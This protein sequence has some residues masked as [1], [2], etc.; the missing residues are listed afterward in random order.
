MKILFVGV[1]TEGSTN[2]SQRDS[3]RRI[4]HDVVEF[5][6]RD[7]SNPTMELSKINDKS[8]DMLLIAK[9]NNIHHDVIRY[10][11]KRNNCKF[12]YWF[13][14]PLMSFSQEMLD[15]ILVSDISYFDKK[16]VLDI[17]KKYHKDC[18]YLCEGYDETIDKVKDVNKE[19][20]VSFIGT[21]YGERENILNNIDN[22]KLIKDAYGEKHS[23]EVAKSR[24]NLNI[25]TDSGASDR[26]YK[27]LA[28][29]GFLLTD[30]WEGRELTGLE[31]K[32]DLV[33]YKNLDDLKSKIKHYLEYNKEREQIAKNG[34]QSVQ[35]LTRE[36]W[37]KGIVSE[38]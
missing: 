3:L 7:F 1:F 20:D 30:D 15:K 27:V 26:I 37:A 11:K 14:D 8:I 5:P 31:D 13:M 2:V 22:V 21:V 16:N 19:Y 24:I 10:F 34:L 9:G 6:Y 25:C 33:I 23:I 29:G 17:A 32:K 4:G 28:S 36:A 12:V 38:K 35:R 18:Y